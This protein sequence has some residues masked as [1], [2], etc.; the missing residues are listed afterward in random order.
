MFGNSKGRQ[1]K[2]LFLWIRNS[3]KVRFSVWNIIF[4][5]FKNHHLQVSGH[6]IFYIFIP[7][8]IDN[9]FKDMPLLIFNTDLESSYFFNGH[10][11]SDWLFENSATWFCEDSH[12]YL[13]GTSSLSTH[14]LKRKEALD[15]TL[16]WTKRG[17]MRV[18]FY[19]SSS[20]AFCKNMR[21]QWY[22]LLSLQWLQNKGKNKVK[23]H[24]YYV[25]WNGNSYS[26]IYFWNTL[27]Y[28]SNSN[29]IFNKIFLCNHTS[30]TCK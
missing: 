9:G 28:K 13:P 30:K 23:E 2:L 3:E 5:D 11:I 18:N 1:K 27:N 6:Q 17:V 8:L 21:W 20:C 15:R 14:L 7:F 10:C 29:D 25:C 4:G 24:F 19:L 26:L 22:F 16:L 12:L